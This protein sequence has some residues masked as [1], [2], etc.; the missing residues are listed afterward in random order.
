MNVIKE[1]LAELAIV[2]QDRTVITYTELANKVNLTLGSTVIP[3]VG[4]QFGRVIGK[5]LDTANNVCVSLKRPP[6]S[7]LVVRADTDDDMPGAGFWAW[8]DNSEDYRSSWL[9]I[10]A[11]AKVRAIREDI[12]NI[13]ASP[14]GIKQ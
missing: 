12:Y 8:C 6:L 9:G 5:A 11:K 13:Y 3:V 10:D 14:G 4:S 7:A 2:A 1:I